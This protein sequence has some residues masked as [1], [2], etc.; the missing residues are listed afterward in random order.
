MKH[1]RK[2]NSEKVQKAADSFRLSPK[3]LLR[4][5]K[6]NEQYYR[7]QFDRVNKLC[8]SLRAK[9]KELETALAK[10]TTQPPPF[11]S[12]HSVFSMTLSPMS[13]TLD[14][15]KTTLPQTPLTL[16][17]SQPTSSKLPPTKT[18]QKQPTL[19]LHDEA[20]PPSTNSK[21]ITTKLT[22]TTPPHLTERIKQ[23]R[24]A[25]TTSTSPTTHEPPNKKLRHVM[26]SHPASI[27]NL[28]VTNSTEASNFFQFPTTQPKFNYVHIPCQQRTTR[29]ETRK[30]LR[31]LNINTARI[32][33]ISFPGRNIIGLLVHHHYLPEIISIMKSA[34]IP[35]LND[36]DPTHQ[37]NLKDPKYK[38][39][40]ISERDTISKQCH[41]TRCLRAIAAQPF[42]LMGKIASFF[43]SQGWIYQADYDHVIS[44]PRQ[45]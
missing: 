27:N 31:H 12:T 32:L 10:K 28:C 34:T 36:F 3:D 29:Q 11:L 33:D 18:H 26:D 22:A 21:N 19:N 2:P 5:A 30:L 43:N 40:S 15:P 14:K 20:T 38:K 41:R 37:D 1:Y 44:S 8:E 13:T 17:P 9:V 23:A 4:Q 25:P 16:S 45:L 35:I 42:T 7:Q 24:P 39:C 6:D